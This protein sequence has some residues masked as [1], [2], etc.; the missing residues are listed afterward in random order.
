VGE[1][2]YH[3][4]IHPGVVLP[5]VG[6]TVSGEP[7]GGHENLELARGVVVLCARGMRDT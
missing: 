6:L 5:R 3:I 7:L 4:R 1:P 2:E